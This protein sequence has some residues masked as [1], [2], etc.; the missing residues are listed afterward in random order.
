MKTGPKVDGSTMRRYQNIRYRLHRYVF[1]LCLMYICFC[2]RARDKPYHSPISQQNIPTTLRVMVL[3][4]QRCERSDRLGANKQN[5]GRRRH[6]HNIQN[7]KTIP[8]FGITHANNRNLSFT[9]DTRYTLNA[10]NIQ[11]RLVGRFK[12]DF[13]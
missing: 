3:A 1:L 8:L 9:C 12:I 5:T 6:M 11:K 7:I 13:V 10:E 4:L 2:W